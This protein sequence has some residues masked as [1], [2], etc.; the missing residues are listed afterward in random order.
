MKHFTASLLK[1]IKCNAITHIANL[2]HSSTYP[3]TYNTTLLP[4]VS[5]VTLGTFCGVMHTQA[6]TQTHLH[7]HIISLSH[8]TNYTIHVNHNCNV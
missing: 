1:S 6:H 7:P 5:R 3:R 2:A 4:S 8:N